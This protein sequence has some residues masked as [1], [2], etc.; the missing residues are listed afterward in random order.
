[1][2]TPEELMIEW[3]RWLASQRYYQDAPSDYNGDR[4]AEL[5]AGRD[6]WLIAG[7]WGTKEHTPRTLRVPIGKSLFIVASFACVT[8]KVLKEP[9]RHPRA[10]AAFNNKSKK[11]ADPKDK[12]LEMNVKEIHNTF[13]AIKLTIDG[14]EVPLLEIQPPVFSIDIDGASGLGSVYGYPGI[15]RTATM[16]KAY[17]LEYLG[18]PHSIRIEAKASEDPISGEPD[19]EMDVTYNIVPS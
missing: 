18:S 1:M 17:L 4:H 13:S 12:D 2:K 3:S 19:Y 7:T 14:A 10:R 5:N 16:G 9:R 11:N 8:D 15:Q 6:T